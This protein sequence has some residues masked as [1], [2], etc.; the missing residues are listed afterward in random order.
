MKNSNDTIGNRTRD[1]PA[2]SAVPQPTAPLGTP[3]IPHGLASDRNPAS[4]AADRRLPVN[5]AKKLN[6]ERLV[7]LKFKDFKSNGEVMLY[8]K[9]TDVVQRLQ[10]LR[11]F[12]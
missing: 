6:F 12:C 10:I 7:I 8:D 3:Q 11:G 2:C 4:T 1:L 9:A 5:N